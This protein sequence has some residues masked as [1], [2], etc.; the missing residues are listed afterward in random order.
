ML[1]KYQRLIDQMEDELPI[2][3][4][5]R[6]EELLRSTDIPADERHVCGNDLGLLTKLVSD[7]LGGVPI[8]RSLTPGQASHYNVRYRKGICVPYNTLPFEDDPAGFLAVRPNSLRVRAQIY[9][10]ETGI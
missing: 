1:D 9:R 7:W 5:K 3:A 8:N 10:E 6:R 4:F 2:L